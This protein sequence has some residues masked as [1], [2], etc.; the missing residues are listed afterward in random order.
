MSGRVPVPDS[1]AVISLA[2]ASDVAAVVQLWSANA[3]EHGGNFDDETRLRVHD[4]VRRAVDDSLSWVGVAKIG[5][6]AVGFAFGALVRHPVYET[7]TGHI[8]ELFVSKSV[9]GRGVGR[10]LVEDMTRRLRD[11]GAVVVRADADREDP[12]AN[13][14]WRAVGVVEFTRYSVE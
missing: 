12:A 4:V 3:E 10:R 1:D 9:R 7:A 14:F 5:T 2:A 8:E 11:R 13:A 6:S